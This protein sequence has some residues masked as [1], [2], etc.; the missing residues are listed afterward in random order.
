MI[1]INAQVTVVM[2]CVIIVVHALANVVGLETIAISLLGVTKNSLLLGYCWLFVLFCCWLLLFWFTYGVYFI[3]AENGHRH[4]KNQKIKAQV[5]LWP[6]RKE[7]R[8]SMLNII[9]I[10]MFKSK[11]EA[12]KKKVRLFLIRWSSRP[13]I[14]WHFFHFHAFS[15]FPKLRRLTKTHFLVL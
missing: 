15:F 11:L 8:T 12:T 4:V 14:R 7:N 5:W 3:M 10:K 1:T 2:V 9:T 13:I 6:I